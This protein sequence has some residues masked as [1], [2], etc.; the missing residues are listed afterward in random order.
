MYVSLTLFVDKHEE[1]CAETSQIGH[2]IISLLSMF[3]CGSIKWSYYL[4]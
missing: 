1:Y 3:D 4:G 2:S